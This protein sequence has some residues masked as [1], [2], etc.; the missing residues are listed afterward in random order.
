VQFQADGA[1]SG[2]LYQDCVDKYT[3]YLHKGLGK[4]KPLVKALFNHWNN[5]LFPGQAQR[6][7]TPEDVLAAHS[8]LDAETS[9]NGN[10]S[11]SDR[12]VEADGNQGGGKGA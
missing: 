11:E 4:H 12:E 1:E 9:D 10:N 2:N 8:I 5:K 3:N 6:K 7:K